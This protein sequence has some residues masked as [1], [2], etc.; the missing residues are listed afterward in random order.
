MALQEPVA[1]SGLWLRRFGAGDIQV[2]IERDGQWYLAINEYGE[3]ISHICEPLG[4]LNAPRDPLPAA[5]SEE[6]Q[7]DERRRVG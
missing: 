3:T 6:R 5:P 7:S 4:M 2:L 1:I